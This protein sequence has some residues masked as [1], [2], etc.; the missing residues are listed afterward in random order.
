MSDSFQVLGGSFLNKMLDQVQVRKILKFLIY[1]FYFHDI[2]F[3]ILKIVK[4]KISSFLQ[5]HLNIPY[6]GLCL[7]LLLTALCQSSSTSTAIF[8]TLVAADLFTVSQVDPIIHIYSKFNYQNNHW[9]WNLRFE[10][11]GNILHHG[12]KRRNVNYEVRISWN[13]ENFNL[14]YQVLS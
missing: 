7:G 14:L 5:D 8:I 3:L 2:L 9:N 12:G 13:F 4:S 6:C 10:N 11:S 1:F